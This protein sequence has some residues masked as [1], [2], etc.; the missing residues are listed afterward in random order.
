MRQTKNLNCVI[1]K[2]NA[3]YFLAAYA[4]NLEPRNRSIEKYYSMNLLANL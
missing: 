2:V 3:P 1:F 4:F